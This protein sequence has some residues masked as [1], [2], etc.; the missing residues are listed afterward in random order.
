MKMPKSTMKI[1][2]RTKL[3]VLLLIRQLNLVKLSVVLNGDD[4]VYKYFQLHCI[5][6]DILIIDKFHADDSWVF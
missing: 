1:K 4:L 6:L 3:D 2:K 5:K